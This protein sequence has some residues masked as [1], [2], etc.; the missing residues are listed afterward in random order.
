MDILGWILLGLLVGLVVGVIVGLRLHVAGRRD[1]QAQTAQALAPVTQAMSMLNQRLTEVQRDR[2]QMGA[3]LR[4][5]VNTVV[6]TN[7]NLRRETN[8]LATAL[9]KP[10]VRGAWGETQLKRVVELAGM[11][12]HVDFVQQET[13][14]TPAGATIRPDLKVLLGDGKFCYV[15]AKV[16]LQGFLDAQ[17]ATT[18]DGQ[19]EALNRFAANVRT[20]ID[21]L[22]A[23]EYWTAGPGSPEFVVLF[24]PSEAL[25]AEAYARIPELLEYASRR[26]IILATPTSLIGLLQAVA[27]GWKQIALADSAGEVAALGRELYQRLGGLSRHLDSVGKSLNRAVS[28][29]NSSVGALES[30]V[31]VTARKLSTLQVADGD[32]PAPRQVLTAARALIPTEPETPVTIADRKAQNESE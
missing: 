16:P 9:R 31:Q 23:K 14:H 15:D 19:D 24:L 17:A 11:V 6:A 2:A 7:E 26:N 8:Q 27:Y 10:Q 3:E 12:E 29:Y 25:A 5:Q 30:R 20:H 28:E 13:A 22:S 4:Q 1:A 18:A 21:Q 32:L